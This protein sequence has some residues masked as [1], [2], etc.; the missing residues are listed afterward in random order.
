LTTR[1]LLAVE[2]DALDLALGGQ[3]AGAP[4]AHVKPD[5]SLSHEQR[6]LVGEACIRP[7]RVVYVVCVAGAGKTTALRAVADAYADVGVPVVGAAP[8]GRAA[9]ELAAATGMPSATLHRLLVDARGSGGLPPHSVL[10]V[11]EAGMA[12]TRVLVPLLRLVDEAGGRAILVGDPA[13]L[14]AVGAGGLFPAF[15]EQLGAIEL[16]ENRRQVNPVERAALARLRAGDAEPYLAHAA[17]SGRL[18]V[19]DDPAAAKQ[20]L[21][22]DWWQCAEYDLTGTVMVA[23]R[24][25]DVQT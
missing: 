22:M 18:H 20:R 6:A 11:D 17:S 24:C 23:H 2:R 12:Q 19:G 21:L 8:S 25:N 7:D 10:V 5:S 16:T 13:Q 15:C 4:H 9:D 14:P 1:E 3:G